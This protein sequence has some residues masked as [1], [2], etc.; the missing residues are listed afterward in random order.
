MANL[1]TAALVMLAAVSVQ[2]AYV[3]VTFSATAD[4]TNFGYTQGE[5][6]S[7]TWVV[8]DGFTGGGNDSFTTAEGGGE[9]INYWE[10]YHASDPMLIADFS[11][12]GLSGTYERASG[13]YGL[14]IAEDDDLK[15]VSVSDIYYGASGLTAQGS[16]LYGAG[17]K[18]L[19]VTG[20]S[21]TFTGEFVNPAEYLAQRE[22]TYDVT[23][24]DL[25]L[26]FKDGVGAPTSFYFTP[27]EFTIEEVPE[28]ATMALLGLGGLFIR[29]KRT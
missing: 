5:S 1:K 10:E 6:Y 22:G 29:R 23:S 28:P 4:S 25:Y 17:A 27:D 14:I 8:N 3:S 15:N 12:D 21:N 18:E 13:P 19:E 20:F 7:F 11:G 26:S 24:G 9:N 2:A 16:S